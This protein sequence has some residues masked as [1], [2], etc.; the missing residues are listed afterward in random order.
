[1]KKI[2]SNQ[3]P[4]AIGPYSQA[5]QCGILFISSGQLGIDPQTGIFAGND[6][7]RQTM[8]ALQNLKYILAESN[9]TEHNVLKTTVFL[10]NIDDFDAMNEAYEEFFGAHKPARSCVEVARLPKNALV[11]IECMASGCSDYSY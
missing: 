10:A 1:M 6:V 2:N 5:V 8:Q 3:A 7:R 9:Y 4:A 11:E